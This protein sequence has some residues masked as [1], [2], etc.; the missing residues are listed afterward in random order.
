MSRLAMTT[1]LLLSRR[2]YA[3]VAAEASRAPAVDEEVARAAA[4]GGEQGASTREKVFWMRD[5]KTGNWMPEN[6]FGELDVAEL[7]ARFLSFNHRK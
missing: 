7:R 1:V 2:S 3:V 4:V 5:P 6:R